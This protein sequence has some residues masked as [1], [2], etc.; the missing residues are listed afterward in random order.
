MAIPHSQRRRRTRPWPPEGA[1]RTSPRRRAA[2]VSVARDVPGAARSAEMVAVVLTGETLVV[3][4]RGALSPA[5]RDLARTPEGDALVREFHRTLFASACGPLRQE[6]G[7]ITGAGVRQ[8]SAE[9]H[10]ATGT[11]VL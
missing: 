4:L 10:G 3:T 8:A 11:V 9:A 6:V 1:G 2:A 7:R 5:E